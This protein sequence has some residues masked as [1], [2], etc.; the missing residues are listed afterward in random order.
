[1]T[2]RARRPASSTTWTDRGGSGQIVSSGEKM[3]IL[4]A[5]LDEASFA[6]TPSGARDGIRFAAAGACGVEI[7]RYAPPVPR[8]KRTAPVF[9]FL[10]G[11]CSRIHR[12]IPGWTVPLP[13]AL[14]GVPVAEREDRAVVGP[15]Q[16]IIDDRLHFMRG[17]LELPVHGGDEPFTWTVWV[18]VSKRTFARA[19]ALW[20]EEGREREPPYPGK[21]ANELPT[22]PSTLGL[23]VRLQERPVGE[24]PL[25][26][27]EGSHPLAREQREGLSAERVTELASLTPLI[28]EEP[29][30]VRAVRQATLDRFGPPD[31]THSFDGRAPSNPGPLPRIDVLVWR[32]D[33]DA[34]M[35]TF[36]SVGMSARRMSGGSRAEVH[37]TIRAA[38]SAREERAAACFVANA[39][40]YPFDHDRAL[41]WWH[42]ISQPGAIP[43][44]PSCSALLLHPRFVPDGWDRV[45]RGRA[46]VKL[47]NLVPITAEER[48]VVKERGAD[49]LLD[50]WAERAVDVFRD[51]ETRPARRR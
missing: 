19:S 8:R 22:Y 37:F 42:L 30:L 45:R 40:C 27:V 15:S 44:Y 13:D 33:G 25:L 16:C 34:D 32:P 47:L 2:S 26:L 48:L 50:L 10:C 39:A 12:G 14:L 20:E 1:M 28:P 49:A 5:S 35:T 7:L 18:A 17:N 29:P 41:G 6:R 3:P 31:S 9:E 43:G 38:L 21:L 46:E 23:R 51:R 24:R 4:S 11:S 36:C